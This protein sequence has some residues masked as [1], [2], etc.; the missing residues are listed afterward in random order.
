MT[1]ARSRGTAAA[2]GL[3]DRRGLLPR[4]RLC[5]LIRARL[6]LQHDRLGFKSIGH[7][8]IEKLRFLFYH[9]NDHG[10]WTMH[11]PGTMAGPWAMDEP[12]TMIVA[13]ATE[14]GTV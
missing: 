11:G 5:F 8:G 2:H 6:S 12:W 4:V 7:A 14:K 9:K 13:V 3:P 10:L 1:P